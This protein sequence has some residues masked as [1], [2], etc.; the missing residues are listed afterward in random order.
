MGRPTKAPSPGTR[1]SLGLKVTPAIKSSLDD[2]AKSNGRTQ[3]QEAELRLE[4]SFTEEAA[5]GGPQMRMLALRAGD[6]VRGL[7][8]LIRNGEPRHERADLNELIKTA[9]HVARPEARQCRISP[10]ATKVFPMSVPVAVT[11]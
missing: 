3:S 6:I 8:T 10:T 7:R 9:V 2:A 4:R 11:K 5:L 1:V